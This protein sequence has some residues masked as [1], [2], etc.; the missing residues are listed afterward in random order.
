MHDKFQMSSMGELSFFL[1]LQVQ[2]KSD[3]IFIN[4]EKY[5]ADILKKFDFT[6]VKTASTPMEP[7]KALVK[8]AEAEDVDVHLYR[9]MIGSLMYLT[10]SRPDITFVVCACQP[11]LGLWYPRDSPFDLEAY[12]DSDYAGASLDMKSTIGEYVAAASCCRQVLWIQNLMVDY[13][14]NLMN[15]KIYIDN[16][17]D[18]EG[19]ACLPND[20]IFE[21]LARMGAKTTAWNEFSST[22][23][24]IIICLAKNQKFNFSKYILENM[25]KNLEAG[26]KFFMFPRFIQVFLNHQIGDMSHHKGI[27]VNPSLTK[28]VFANI[29]RVGTCFSGV[30]TPLFETMMVQAPEEKKHKPRRKQ[31]KEIEVSHDE[32]PTEERVPT[33]FY[34]PLPSEQD[35]TVAE[36]VEGIAAATTSQI[37]KD[38]LTLAQTLM[39]IKAAKPKAKGV[40]IYEPSEFRTTSPPQPSQPSHAKEKAAM[41]AKIDEEERIAREKNEANRAIIKE[42]DDVQATIDADSQLAEQIQAQK[43]EQ[44]SIEERSKLLAELIESKRKY[45]TAKRA[46]EIRNKPPTKAQ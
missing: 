15:T 1:G 33:S 10:A 6:T 31:R 22:M 32:I 11:K 16:E 39:E 13:G 9:S 21:G 42:W 28:K 45:F 34:D 19:T 29:K 12:F 40:T 18:A 17:N 37:P 23:A 44:L 2:Q 7:N 24:S 25:V 46:K 20:A 41:K 4:Q 27:F 36:S 43:K 26:V 5:V 38:E 14:F 35:V 8:D 30:T 3:G